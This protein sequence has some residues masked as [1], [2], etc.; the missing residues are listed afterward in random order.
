[1]WQ[2]V[3]Q[4]RSTLWNVPVSTAA[5]TLQPTTSFRSAKPG[6]RKET[7]TWN[8]SFMYRIHG[9]WTTGPPPEYHRNHSVGYLNS[10]IM[11]KYCEVLHRQ[12]KCAYPPCGYGASW[13]PNY[14][15]LWQEITII[16]CKCKLYPQLIKIAWLNDSYG[17]REPRPA[18]SSYQLPDNQGSLEEDMWKRIFGVIKIYVHRDMVDH[19]LKKIIIFLD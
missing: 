4:T 11:C 18:V 15:L 1:M 3:C 9:H 6:L 13:I 8:C 17:S 10:W 14:V 12:S 7:I 2:I 5:R 16:Q 19:P